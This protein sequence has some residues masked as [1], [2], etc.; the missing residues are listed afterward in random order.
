MMNRFPIILFATF[1]GLVGC[2]THSEQVW[3]EVSHEVQP[4]K[5]EQ[6]AP[7][8]QLAAVSVNGD[9]LTPEQEPLAEQVFLQKL[10]ITPTL[11]SSSLRDSV[12]LSSENLYLSKAGELLG[13]LT[14]R[15]NNF[16]SVNHITL[17]CVEYNMNHSAI[18]EASATWARTLRAGESG[19]WDQINF[20]YVHND[21]DTVR[22]EILDA[23]LSS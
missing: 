4:P 20:G 11:K 17:H 21:F 12:I 14:I 9:S 22:C 6:A 15:N 8:V 3:D 23:E 7:A 5:G 16:F 13:D 2:D 18:R 19:Y 1:F 10:K